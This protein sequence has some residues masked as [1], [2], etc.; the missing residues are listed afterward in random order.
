[1]PPN[2]Q[3]EPINACSDTGTASLKEVYDAVGLSIP[4]GEALRFEKA[5]TEGSIGTRFKA[6]VSERQDSI[7][8]LSGDSQVTYAEFYELVLKTA[9][10]IESRSRD[11]QTPIAL[12]GETSISTV[13]AIFACFHLGRPFVFL[14]PA[15]SAETITRILEE[16]G[17][18]ILAIGHGLEHFP[19]LP[20]TD[21]LKEHGLEQISLDNVPRTG[22]PSAHESTATADSLAYIVFTSGSTG[23]P[24]GV[25]QTH[26]NVL[27]DI[28]RQSR[29]LLVTTQDRYGLLFPLGSSAAICHLGGALLNGATL[30][31]IDFRHSNLEDLADWLIQKAVTILDINVSTFRELARTLPIGQ[32]FPDLRLLSPGSEPLSCDDVQLYKDHFS[33]SC[34]LQNAFGTSET[35]TAT[36]YFTH[37]DIP[38]ISDGTHVSIGG[39]VEGKEITLCKPNGREVEPGEVGEMVVRSRFIATGYWNRREKQNRRFKVDPS[40]PAFTLYYTGDLARQLPNG[41]FIH[42]ERKDHCIK[43][44]GF[45]VDLLEIE[46]VIKETPGVADA[47][48]ISY[49][50]NQIP[51]VAAFLIS[52]GNES[53]RT[54]DVFSHLRN[55]L[56]DYMVPAR[57]EWLEQFPVLPNQKTD[58]TSLRRI[59]EAKTKSSLLEEPEAEPLEEG[60]HPGLVAWKSL[61]KKRWIEVLNHREFDQ[62]EEFFDVGGDSL[63]ALRLFAEIKRTTDISFRAED[64]FESFSVNSMAHKAMKKQWAKTEESDS[65]TSLL[66]PLYLDFHEEAVIF[67]PG[68]WGGNA[69]VLLFASLGRKMAR[70]KDLFA[71]LSGAELM[72]DIETSRSALLP[73]KEHAEIVFHEIQTCLGEYHRLTLVGECLAS[74]LTMELATLLERSAF[75]LNPLILLDPWTPSPPLLRILKS[76]KKDR[77]RTTPINS[78]LL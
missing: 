7:A 20:H 77:G 50:E 33:R 58:R 71:L 39:P 23:I 19:E 29:D 63:S 43:I 45:L 24:K 2:D 69:E 38:L 49:R 53:A 46:S 37:H 26:K 73:L 67:I 28:Q 25:P 40:D 54:E 3:N 59:V 18:S 16:T 17:S 8:I 12:Y 70:K 11:S 10:F 76:P 68:G 15:L 9:T 62:D 52:Q 57:I 56:P 21:W 60:S 13:A 41:H 14:S 34:I 64:I 31:P 35:R 78:V 74:S 4:A 66:V 44:R 47:K 75:E 32:N 48:A 22:N 65:G 72:H 42:L 27:A 30:C 61:I 6:V 51:R 1:M 55:R 5:E 36:Q